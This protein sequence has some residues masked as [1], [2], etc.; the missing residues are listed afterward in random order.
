[1]SPSPV[2]FGQVP[3]RSPI[4]QD[5]DVVITNSG[6]APLQFNPGAA[7]F[8]ITGANPGSFRISTNECLTGP[9]PHILA[10]GES[11]IVN[12]VFVPSATTGLRNANLNITAVAAG[13]VTQTIPLS[14]QDTV[15]TISVAPL[16]LNI[17]T[18]P[19]ATVAT[20][21]TITFTNTIS[22]AN[23]NAGPFIPTAITVTRLSG[24]G[25]FA[26]GGT[27]AVGTAVNPQTNCTVTV[28]YTPPAA[29][30]LAGTAR[31]TLTEIGTASAAPFNVIVTAN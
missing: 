28:T 8:T 2:D 21:G 12:V 19:A 4:T 24:T 14:G 31:V 27:C 25:T 22:L 18:V 20:T 3:D 13:G 23:A 26:L 15:A 10:P 30:A 17:T 7:S 29:G 1:V 9:A 5:Q 6:S 11:C 16:A